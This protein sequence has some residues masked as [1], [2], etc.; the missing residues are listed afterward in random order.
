MA[1]FYTAGDIATILREG[2]FKISAN[3]ANAFSQDLDAAAGACVVA[4]GTLMKPEV[5]E[6]LK[7]LTRLVDSLNEV[8][9]NGQLWRVLS[10]AQARGR[11]RNAPRL[12][13]DKFYLNLRGAI[14]RVN[15]PLADLGGA[16]KA[17]GALPAVPSPMPVFVGRLMQF[18][19]EEMAKARE[20]HARGEVSALE[21]ISGCVE[22]PRIR[23]S[24]R[25]DMNAFNC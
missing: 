4:H 15:D 9:L 14:S 7:K 3:Q 2:D 6:E 8:L 20:R 19:E 13:H 24:S 10:E 16:L 23:C 1:E 18:Q 21:Q 5:R 17:V 11:F 12:S 22:C 25:V